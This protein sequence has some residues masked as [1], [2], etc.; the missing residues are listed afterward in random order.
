MVF[1]VF[2]K[3][4]SVKENKMPITIPTQ[5]DVFENVIRGMI[6]PR[7]ES[8]DSNV[9]DFFI[10]LHNAFFHG[11]IVPEIEESDLQKI[12]EHFESLNEIVEKY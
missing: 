1:Q 7:K 12:Y 10:A 8:D 9:K 11:V 6:A 5:L 2:Q 4:L 3:Q